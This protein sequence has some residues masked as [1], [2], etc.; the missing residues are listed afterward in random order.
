MAIPAIPAQGAPWLTYAQGLDDEIR[1]GRLSD[2]ALGAAF[3]R[4]V[5]V[6]AYGAK[7]DGTTDDS[8][9]FRTA[10]AQGAPVYVPA[11]T[12]R[13][14][15][16][17]ANAWALDLP[18]GTRL[19]GPGK[20]ISAP[21]TATS[22]RV[23]RI[24]SSDVHIDGLTIDGNRAAQSVD[25]QRHGITV[26]NGATGIRLTNLTL[27]NH[28]GDGVLVGYS[29][30]VRIANIRTINCGR[31]GVTLYASS[32]GNVDDVTVI[33]CHLEADVQPLDSEPDAGQVTNIRILGNYLRT[34]GN[35]YA[36]TVAGTSTT[37]TFSR[38]W[39]VIGNT[40]IG[41]L[42]VI[43]QD[44]A[45]IIGNTIDARNTT[46]NGVEATFASSNILLTHNEILTAADHH[47]VNMQ[48]S[49]GLRPVGWKVL[50]NLIS[51]LGT[52]ARGINLT[53]VGATLVSG[54]TIRGANG[55]YGI[56][57]QATNHLE[58]LNVVDNNIEGFG[59]GIY[60]APFSTFEVRRLR[61]VG[62]RVINEEASPVAT[63]GIRLTGTASL[64]KTVTVSDNAVSTTYTTA[65][66]LGGTSTPTAAAVAANG[67]TPP[68][69]AVA[70]GSTDLAG[71]ISFG[72]GATPAI[73]SQVTV[74]FSAPFAATPNVTI[75][76]GNSAT[77]PRQPYV[78]SRTTAG[79]NIGFASAATASQAAGTYVVEY[80]VRP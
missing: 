6:T 3:G 62:N 40:L 79:F 76:P 48:S 13:L 8:A 59:V 69:P 66:S 49:T 74:T 5:S 38:G 53:G 35:E 9:A 16:D 52:A 2:T 11:G 70:A 14:S 29:S 47:G 45:K 39:S 17:G 26:T 31:N 23:L 37:T 25:E 55:E 21:G 36:L 28:T 78:I 57:M 63:Y 22:V 18:A 68:A 1:T 10:L 41:A 30:D 34:L 43:N 12:Y 15:Q 58:S 77:S 4:G 54:N 64:F 51:T 27:P 71:E 72:S 65:V 60:A 7:G 75:S 19:N 32:A 67:T 44:A 42:Y 33:G 61:I 73:G 56:H 20:L 46:R 24:A 80:S 50:G